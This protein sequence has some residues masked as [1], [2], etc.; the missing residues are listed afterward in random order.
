MTT[1]ADVLNQLKTAWTTAA[2]ASVLPTTDAPAA[3]LLA[4]D[5]PQNKPKQFGGVLLS[6]KTE[7]CRGHSQPLEM[8]DEPDK[9]RSGFIR[10]KCRH[11]GK[12]LGYRRDV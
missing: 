10:S 7:P 11:C 12:F 3:D 6:Q 8:I 4:T 1:P 9:A 5:A 2:V